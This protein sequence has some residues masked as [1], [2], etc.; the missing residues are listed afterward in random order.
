GSV[1]MHRGKPGGERTVPDVRPELLKAFET[2]DDSA[3]EVLLLPPKYFSRVIEETLPELPQEIG[4]GPSSVL[5]N[6]C[7]WGALSVDFTPQMK[8]RLVIQSLDSAAA[9]ALEKK[10]GE[11]MRCIDQAPRLK[12]IVPKLVQ[13]INV[14]LP[15]AEGDQLLLHLDEKQKEFSNLLSVFMPPVQLVIDNAQRTQSMINL[16]QIGL[17]MHFYHEANKHFPA[18]ASYSKDARPLLSWRVMILPYLAPKLYNQFHLDEPWDSQHNKKLI[19]KMPAVFKSPKSRLKATGKTNYVVPVGPGTVFEP[20]EGMKIKEI[21]DGTSCTI[22]VVEVDDANAV[23]WTKPDDLQ[24]DPKQPAKGLGGL[25]ND[26]F[27]ALY[28]DGS[29]HAL[30]MTSVGEDGL[31]ALFSADGEDAAPRD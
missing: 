1:P 9:A 5:T 16:K 25:F 8:V 23:T 4:G 17:A 24:Y 7:L 18:A 10:L 12:K 11:I 13:S 15:K 29:V 27:L 3:V 28:C 14:L 30:S 31:R 2:T 26:V 19:D 6:G 22:M 21:T 20:K